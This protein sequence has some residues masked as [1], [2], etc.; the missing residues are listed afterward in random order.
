[1]VIGSVMHWT[2]ENQFDS[3]V[4]AFHRFDFYSSKQLVD[5]AYRMY[6]TGFL[7]GIAFH[8]PLK[9]DAGVDVLESAMS[10]YHS[11]SS[12][13]TRFLPPAGAADLK[14]A[15]INRWKFFGTRSLV[16]N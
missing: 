7:T 1:M 15:R 5:Q 8:Y 4:P 16:R 9:L 3:S 13:M 14:H 2:G 11:I 10:D 6:D 12:S